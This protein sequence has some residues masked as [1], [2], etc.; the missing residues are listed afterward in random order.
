[1]TFI[2]LL[3]ASGQYDAEYDNG[4][5]TGLS[6][7]LPMAL[8]ALKRLG[9]DDTRLTE[10]A[11]RYSQRLRPA[12]A[13]GACAG[14]VAGWRAVARAAWPARR[15]AGLPASVFALASHRV[16]RRGAAADRA[17][18]DGGVRRRCVPRPNTHGL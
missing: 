18:V 11:A 1:M 16:R 14:R 4:G 3:D 2:D 17:H 5:L 9:A 12:P 15:L 7:H 10:F 13:P 8:A 6:N